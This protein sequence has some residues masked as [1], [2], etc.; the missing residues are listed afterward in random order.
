MV[1]LFVRLLKFACLLALLLALLAWF[2]LSYPEKFLTVDSGH[3]TGDVIVVL[4]GGGERAVRAA[5]LYH[6]HVAPRILITGQGDDEINRQILLAHGIPARDIEVENKSTTTHENAL[7]SLN[8]LRA[9][10]VHDVILVTSWYH[11][12]RAERTFEHYAPELKFY[13]RPSYYAFQD[14][15]WKST[16]VGK[17]M[18]REFLKIPGYWIWYGINP[19]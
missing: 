18:R 10:K 11:A 15:Q 17:R 4:G 1:K 16:G 6:A 12:R 14:D 19:F 5:E 9:E 2:M 13:S 3:A 7:F 8:I